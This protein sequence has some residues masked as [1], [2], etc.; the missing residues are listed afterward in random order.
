MLA[1]PAVVCVTLVHVQT[2]CF[3]DV[4]NK[5]WITVALVAVEINTNEHI[6]IKVE[7]RQGTMHPSNQSQS[8]KSLGHGTVTNKVRHGCAVTYS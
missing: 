8:M 5:P 4:G 1:T 7:K 6:S 3:I 2:N